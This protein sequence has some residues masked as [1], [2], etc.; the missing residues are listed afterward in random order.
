MK[1]YLQDFYS[2]CMDLGGESAEQMAMLLSARADSIAINIVVNSLSSPLNEVQAE[3][4]RRALFPCF[5]TLYPFSTGSKAPGTLTKAHSDL[6]IKA[7][8]EPFPMYAV[9]LK[10]AEENPS[11]SIDDC[12]YAR[13][14]RLMEVSFMGQFHYGIFYSYVKLKEQEIRNLVWISECIIQGRKDKIDK[15]VPIFGR[16]L[17]KWSA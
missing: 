6:D 13:A 5:G 7:A 17:F 3:E 2:F 8:L 11:K 1:L 14:V 16:D 9:V 10:E 15:Y 4:D 12:F